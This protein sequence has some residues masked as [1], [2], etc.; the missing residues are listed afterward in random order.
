MVGGNHDGTHVGA[1]LL[2]HR[3]CWVGK[4]DSDRTLTHLFLDGYGTG[5]LSVPADL[6]DAFSEAHGR[7]MERGTV[8]PLVQIRTDVFH[9]FA[10]L[11][12]RLDG[13]RDPLDPLALGRSLSTQ[14]ARFVPG[15]RQ[16][17]VVLVTDPPARRGD[18]KQ[19]VHV[20]F[21]GL[22]VRTDQALCMREAGVEALARDFADVDWV[23]DYDNSPYV[24]SV[25]SLR[26]AGAPKVKNC[27]ECGNKRDRRT[28]CTLCTGKGRVPVPRRYV[29]ADVFS[30]TGE[31]DAHAKHVLS[32]NAHQ[33][34]DQTS[35]RS[36]ATSTC[37]EWRPF[38]G[39][40][41]PSSVKTDR[42]TNEPKAGA[43]RRT[44]A[45]DGESMR[46][47]P[48]TKVTLSPA[49][50]K[51]VSTIFR[52]RFSPVYANVC[53]KSAVLG[54]A[55]WKAVRQK[56]SSSTGGGGIGGVGGGSSL[57]GRGILTTAQ[58]SAMAAR[59][60]SGGASSGGGGSNAALLV[61]LSGEGESYC[62]NIGKDHKSNRVYGVV[63]KGVGAYLRCHCTCDTT[64]GRR[65]GF[66]CSDF[67]SPPKPLTPT[68]EA[69]LFSSGPVVGSDKSDDPRNATR[70]PP[71]GMEKYEL[72]LSNMSKELFGE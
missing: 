9:F 37:R 57:V 27:D 1:F 65:S 5:K 30:E 17:C 46:K 6:D 45:E 58:S 72:M 43:K 23:R 50:H 29:L 40:P 18:E 38:D 49:A 32:T 10:D 3:H 39:C 24:G 13:T 7:D 56:A 48:R 66:R 31:P 26:V 70:G 2:S 44:F 15:R 36:S 16:R 21:P 28:E 63:E 14:M 47:W 62:L 8:P 34:V 51:E 71:P 61:E 11:D 68:Q 19:G 64:M 4:K 52:T 20:H 42:R 55:N 25:G 33:L 53:V 41:Q 67:C 60:R 54:T 69:I 35:I 22:L 59:K 12:I